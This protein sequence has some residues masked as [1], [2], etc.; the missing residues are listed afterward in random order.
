MQPS[1]SN[2][3]RLIL[4]TARRVLVREGY[5]ALSMRRLAREIGYSATSI[6]LHFANKD[7]LMHALI[8][9]GMDR[10]HATFRDCAGAHERE[11]VACLRALCRAY[12]SFGLEN[13]EYYEVMFMAHPEHMARYPAEKYRRARRSLDVLAA[14]LEEGDRLGRLAVPQP[15]VSASIIWAALHGT[16][17]LLLARRVDARIDVAAFIDAAIEQAIR[18]VLPVQAAD[19]EDALTPSNV[20]DWKRFFKEVA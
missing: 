14:V 20:V 19:V 4:D 9:E 11:P 7:A 3:R 15:R 1:T 8:E 12:V 10:L 6:Y 13:R 16:V 17:A 5:K 18:G 2:L